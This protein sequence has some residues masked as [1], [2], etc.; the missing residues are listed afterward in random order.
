MIL[1]TLMTSL[2][3]GN[4]S[5]T[6]SPAN[7]ESAPPSVGNEGELTL[8]QGK[9]S[10]KYALDLVAWVVEQEADAPAAYL[11]ILGEPAYGQP[12]LAFYVKLPEGVE[13][14]ELLNTPLKLLATGPGGQGESYAFFPDDDHKV[15]F[16]EGAF[17]L[18]AMT[19]SGPWQIDVGVELQSE[20]KSF[21]GF[22][23]AKLTGLS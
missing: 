2:A 8:T 21:K 17:T 3:M 16:T 7:D 13:D 10:R 4:W 1:S 23:K 18:I 12:E 5:H 6:P 15:L 11:K 14:R 9:K 20:D 22:M 19:G